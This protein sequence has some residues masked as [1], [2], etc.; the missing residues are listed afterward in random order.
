MLCDIL[1]TVQADMIKKLFFVSLRAMS[2]W[3]FF[4]RTPASHSFSD[5]LI[6][7]QITCLQ[8]TR[9]YV[10]GHGVHSHHCVLVRLASA[11]ILFPPFVSN[12]AL[13]SFPEYIVLSSGS[14]VKPYHMISSVKNWVDIFFLKWFPYK[15]ISTMLRLQ[16]EILRIDPL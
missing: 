16:K 14:S 13:A 9:R 7:Y 4:L 1:L 11:V 10:C 5:I 15:V 2:G 8:Y 12:A 3:P 6:P